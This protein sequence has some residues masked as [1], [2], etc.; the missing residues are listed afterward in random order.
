MLVLWSSRDSAHDA[1]TKSRDMDLQPG[2]A[3]PQAISI[4]N[5][6]Q[7]RNVFNSIIH[8]GARYEPIKIQRIPSNRP[9]KN[10]NWGIGQGISRKL[11]VASSVSIG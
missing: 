8:F 6:S 11:E 3:C 9:I 4:Q 2:Q 7:I 5:P 10:P 1:K